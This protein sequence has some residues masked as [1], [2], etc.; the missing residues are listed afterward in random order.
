MVVCNPFKDVII[1]KTRDTEPFEIFVIRLFF[2]FGKIM[3]TMTRVVLERKKINKFSKNKFVF[4][5]SKEEW[6]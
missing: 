1:T 4:F 3:L 6:K 5:F 2:Y